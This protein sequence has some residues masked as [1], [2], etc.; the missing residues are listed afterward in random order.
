MYDQVKFSHSIA[1]LFVAK[2]L[3]KFA[4][5]LM[6]TNNCKVLAFTSMFTCLVVFTCCTI[7]FVYCQESQSRQSK[8]IDITVLRGSENQCPS[9]Q[10]RQQAWDSIRQEILSILSVD[11]NACGG[12]GWR[13]VAFFNMTDTSY[14]CPPGLN[15]TSYSTRTCGRSHAEHTNCS[16]TTFSVGGSAYRRVCGR[17]Q[18]YQWGYGWGLYNY[19]YLNQGIN[20]HYVDGISLTHGESG[21]RQHIWTFIAGIYDGTRWPDSECPCDVNYT[22]SLPDFMGNDYFCESVVRHESNFE[23][24]FFPD[25]PLWDGQH[26]GEGSNMCCQVNNPP[27]FKKTLPNPTADDIELRMC[28]WGPHGYTDIPI[29]SIEIYVQ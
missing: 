21:Q 11:Q 22:Y 23:Q 27:W 4:S 14:N 17:I 16:H 5:Q 2:S 6:M 20:G 7:Q 12:P 9:L 18:A 29:E 26:C 19:Y 3:Q 10:D 28:S 13:Q 8:R 1:N 24:D 25:N 15:L